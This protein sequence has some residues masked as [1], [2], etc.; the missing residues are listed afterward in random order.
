MLRQF[1]LLLSTT[2]IINEIS[3]SRKSNDQFKRSVRHYQQSECEG[4]LPL[5]VVDF[6]TVNFNF[7]PLVWHFCSAKSTNKIEKRQ[8]RALRFLYNDHVSSYNDLLLKSQRCTMHVSRLR[9]LSLA[10][11]KTLHDLNPSLMKDIFQIRTS[12]YS[13]RNP[14]NLTHYRPNQVTFGTNSLKSL[15][16]RIW[17]CLPE[18]L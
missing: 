10:I 15:G 8:E 11:F 18:D 14:N 13:S 12:N 9:S 6:T 17:N 1:F 16:P 3:F 4:M 2:C 7:C 5:D